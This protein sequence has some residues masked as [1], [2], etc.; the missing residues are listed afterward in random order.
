MRAGPA[1]VGATPQAELR[2]CTKEAY[3]QHQYKLAIRADPPGATNYA[4]VPGAPTL[5]LC[6]GGFATA[7]AQ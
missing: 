6:P 1:D 3:G 7:D 4:L 5:D 2:T